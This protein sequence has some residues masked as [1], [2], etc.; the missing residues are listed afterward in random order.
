MSEVTNVPDGWEEN[1]I[2]ELVDLAQGIAIN[3]KTNYVLSDKHN[4]IP[5]LKINN[6]INNTIDQYANP[7]LVPKQTVIR[8]NDIIFTRTGQVGEVFINKHGI[9]HNNSF[10]VIPKEKL[11][12]NYL[13]WFL[14]SSTVYSYVQKVA[15]GS[16]QKDLNHS[17]FKTI[18]IKYPKDINEQQSIAQILTAFNDKIELLQTQNKTLETLAQTIFSEWFGK[19]KIEDELPEGWRVEKLGDV[20]KTFG[21]TT[22]STKNPEFWDGEICWTSPKDLSN[23][24]GIFLLNTEKRITKEG[25]KNI[26]SGLL[27]IRTLLL[28]SRAPIGYLALTNI[29]LAINQGYIA[30]VPNQYFS[31]N[32]MY[33][34]LNENMKLIESASNGSTFMEISKSSFRNI[35]CVVP[36]KSILEKFDDL[37]NPIFEKILTNLIQIQTLTETRDELLPKLMSGEIRVKM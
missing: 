22:P 4:G 29:E 18:E 14:K 7:N 28:S 16:V 27:P 20:T 25:L 32:Y 37:I 10:K 23:S 26:S 1:N 33:L 21:G 17:A 34:W 35:E 24:K 36:S 13:Y 5:L 30:L 19:Y 8:K 12:W 11:H 6:L 9:L 15:G 31:N 3:A 2:G